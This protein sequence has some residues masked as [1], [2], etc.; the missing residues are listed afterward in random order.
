[1]R[2]VTLTVEAKSLPQGLAWADRLTVSMP[3]E[4]A[5]LLA[6][7]LSL[8]SAPGMQE[9][10]ALAA[11]HLRRCAAYTES[12][13]ASTRVIGGY[14]R[15]PAVLRTA[16]GHGIGLLQRHRQTKWARFPGWPIDLSA[17]FASDLAGMPRSLPRN[18][19]ATPVLLSHDID[20]AEGLENL[21]SKFLTLEE[22]V[23]ARSASYVVPCAWPIDHGLMAEIVGRGHEIGI[24][25]YDHGNRTPFAAPDERKRRLEAARELARRY[26]ATGYR[27]P[28]LLRTKALLEDLAAYYKYDSSIPT[29][30]GAFPVPN[31]GCASA[32]P[33]KIGTLWEIPLTLPRDGSLR[34]LGHGPREI[35][36]VWRDVA[37]RIWASGGV[38]SLLT[39]CEARFSGNRAMLRVYEDFLA[40]LAADPRF[41]FVLPNELV[42]RLDGDPSHAGK[43][44]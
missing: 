26:N 28:S 17:D 12:P 19:T 37:E 31:N 22:A 21:V 30:G 1:M 9:L 6:G 2:L 41:E 5:A 23:G 4:L 39:H 44:G 14:Q 24:H 32:R 15:I 20:S 34:F 25:G 38:V 8:A 13:P 36:R 11:G 35:G 42:A 33:W 27:A 7:G 18:Q 43:A 40:W 16:I 10:S 3:Q 29:S